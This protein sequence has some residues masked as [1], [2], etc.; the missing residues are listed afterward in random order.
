MFDE[1]K[2]LENLLKELRRA[3]EKIVKVKKLIDLFNAELGSSVLVNVQISVS[4]ND[5]LQDTL[6]RS[7]NPVDP[8]YEITKSYLIN[9]LQLA[10]KEEKEKT[11]KLISIAE[12]IANL[13]RE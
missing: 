9:I 1:T 5:W 2:E 4:D 11:N 6:N 10:E 8:M 7:F 12:E 13:G 3:K